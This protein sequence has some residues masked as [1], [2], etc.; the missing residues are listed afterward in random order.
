MWKTRNYCKS[1]T[2]GRDAFSQPAPP[3]LDQPNDRSRCQDVGEVFKCP[4]YSARLQPGQGRPNVS[5]QSDERG[6]DPPAVSR[7][8]ER[9]PRYYVSQ[10]GYLESE[11]PVFA[12]LTLGAK[13]LLHLLFHAV[14][15]LPIIMV[16]LSFLC[17]GSCQYFIPSAAKPSGKHGAATGGYRRS[18][19]SAVPNSQVRRGKMLD[20]LGLRQSALRDSAGS[21]KLPGTHPVQLHMLFRCE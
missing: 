21:H 9:Y 3:F 1:G 5:L 14:V 10:W 16:H 11:T 2:S 20:G 12:M 8:L 15:Q 6:R 19:V 18:D 17:S 13:I 4:N 7:G